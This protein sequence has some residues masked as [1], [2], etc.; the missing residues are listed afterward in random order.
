M[1]NFRLGISKIFSVIS[2]GLVFASTS[3]FATELAIPQESNVVL[4]INGD[5][6]ITN[7]GETAQFDREMLEALGTET[8]VTTTIWTQGEQ[9]FT[10]VPLK[11]ILNVMGVT[12]GTLDAT[13]VNDYSVQF[14]VADELEGAALVAFLLN[15][16]EMGVRE[17]GPLWIVFPFDSDAKF[18]SETYYSRSIWQLDRITVHR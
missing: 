16:K 8:I 5:I 14:S 4:T 10:G 7:V 18:Q 6:E 12:E 9:E 11:R 3:V 15:G 1:F 2:C 13:A 17:K